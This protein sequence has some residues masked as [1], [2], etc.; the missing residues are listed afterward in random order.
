MDVHLEQS[1]TSSINNQ[2]VNGKGNEDSYIHEIGV[3]LPSQHSL[4]TTPASC[5]HSE[6]HLEFEIPA[7]V[8]QTLQDGT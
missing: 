1:N 6:E 2:Q 8:K 3:A 5:N 7:E 4:L